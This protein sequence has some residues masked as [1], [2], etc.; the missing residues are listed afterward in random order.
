VFTQTS[1]SRRTRR[2]VIA[3]LL[4]IFALLAVACGDDG[5]GDDNAD[6]NDNATVQE[7]EANRLTLWATKDLERTVAAI[8][9]QHE[10]RHP[11]QEIEVVYA[12]SQELNDKLLL[13]ERPDLLLGTARQLN[14]LS[15]EGS[16]PDELVDF[17]ADPL[18]IVVAPG[19][20]KN[21]TSLDVFG[22]DAGTNVGL[23]AP[24]VGC[25]RSARRA[26]SDA[27]VTAAPDSTEPDAKTLLDKIAD[28]QLDAGILAR[29]QVA[30]AVR[31]GRVTAIDLP[32][33]TGAG[34]EFKIAVIRRGGA[35]NAFLTYLDESV[36][37][38]KILESNGLLPPPPAPAPEQP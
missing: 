31:N 28:G 13:G 18:Q 22:I 21:I 37:V 35:V 36:G 29:T 1:T 15:D 6:Q 14:T 4:A 34:N 17:G 26:L 38:Q 9:R 10:Q 3:G 30:K 27:R 5:G 33:T 2:V 32:S 11:D 19:N 8:L 23:C 24:D 20:P 25:G 12:P 7:G 16:I